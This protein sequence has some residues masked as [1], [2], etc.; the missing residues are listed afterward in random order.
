MP[1]LNYPKITKGDAIFALLS[2]YKLDPG[3]KE[4]WE[5]AKKPYL[6]LLAQFVQETVKFWA[7]TN[8]TPAQYY[9]RVVD[10]YSAEGADPFPAGDFA[11]A[12]QLQPYF[13]ALAVLTDKWKL[14]ANWAVLAFFSF[15]LF[16]ELKHMGIPEQVD[17]PLEKVDS[18]F[19]WQP[20]EPPLHIEVPAFAVVLL[21]RKRILSEI[22]KR[23]RDYEAGIKASGLKEYP[24]SLQQYAQWWF[25]HYVNGRTYKQLAKQFPDAL[26]ESIR[27]AVWKFSKLIGVSVN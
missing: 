22:E 14:K 7:E 11:S 12:P 16:D 6:P 10:F 26:E 21:G 4:E 19:P 20:P 13:D 24:S 18:M 3:F 23:L 27:R 8:L 17:I 15:D 5:Q 1:K 2:I 9:D 25:L